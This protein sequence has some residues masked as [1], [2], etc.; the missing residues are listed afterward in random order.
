MLRS[1]DMEKCVRDVASGIAGSY[2][3]GSARKGNRAKA[4]IGTSS[5][6]EYRDNLQ[7]NTLLKLLGGSG[8]ANG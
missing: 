1:A 6:E 2:H 5:K 4:Y 3:V 8:K 7:N